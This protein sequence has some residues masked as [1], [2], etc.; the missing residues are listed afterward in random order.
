MLVK[1]VEF[2]F[3]LIHLYP[4]SFL[5]NHQPSQARPKNI[6]EDT[7]LFDREDSRSQDVS[8]LSHVSTSHHY[9]TEYIGNINNRQTGSGRRSASSRD[10]RQSHFSQAFASSR[11][12]HGSSLLRRNVGRSDHNSRYD[13]DGEDGDC[14]E[15]LGG[16]ESGNDSDENMDISQD[17]LPVM[18]SHIRPR[19]VAGQPSTSS[20]VEETNDWRKDGLFME[21]TG[22]GKN[23]RDEVGCIEDVDEDVYIPQNEPCK[24]KADVQNARQSYIS[25][26]SSVGSAATRL[27]QHPA[28]A[29]LAKTK[30]TNEAPALIP[31]ENYTGGDDWLIEDITTQPNKRKRMD[32]D[33]MF[34]NADSVQSNSPSPGPSGSQL[35]ATQRTSSLSRKSRRSRQL[36]LTSM[37][38]AVASRQAI[39]GRRVPLMEDD[40]RPDSDMEFSP[41]QVCIFLLKMFVQ[42]SFRSTNTKFKEIS[43]SGLCN[44]S[45]PYVK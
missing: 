9:Q 4:F 44:I 38:S 30:V 2:E 36:K 32:L 18:A 10:K 26:V 5:G 34:R 6:L 35:R 43:F 22:N 1:Y 21:S 24:S 17:S 11:N 8:R 23:T 39:E 29:N 45:L 19:V 20:A 13:E 12:K 33:Y 40:S 25:A 15:T 27:I 42:S 16:A 28:Q 7:D 3:Q 14:F 37:G 41:I 31:E